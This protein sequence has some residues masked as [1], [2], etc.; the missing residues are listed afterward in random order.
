MPIC[1]SC[2]LGES[3]SPCPLQDSKNPPLADVTVSSPEAAKKQGEK[4][5]ADDYMEQ[6]FAQAFLEVDHPA[7]LDALIAFQS[8][9]TVTGY[10]YHTSC[11]KCHNLLAVQNL[12][13][14]YCA[15]Q[16]IFEY[17]NSIVEKRPKLIVST[18]RETGDKPNPF[19]RLWDAATPKEL[20]ELCETCG[21]SIINGRHACTEPELHPVCKKCHAV[22]EG[23]QK[24]HVCTDRCHRCR[25]FLT[26]GWH[27]CT[28]RVCTKCGLLVFLG[29]HNCARDNQ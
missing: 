9:D 28:S 10:E 25:E 6:V 5:L 7:P 27:K 16:D 29:E 8:G 24:F 20:Y 23:Y 22:I 3:H 13:S 12:L 17:L 21:T 19:K 4:R 2:A 18:P 26:D 11:I 14:H 15:D 1:V